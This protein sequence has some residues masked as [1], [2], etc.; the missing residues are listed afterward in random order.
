M[1]IGRFRIPVAKEGYPF[2]L[3]GVV[4]TLVFLFTGPSA[5][6]LLFFLGTA[7]TIFFFRDPERTISSEEGAILS[8]A[9]GRI[10]FAGRVFEGRYLRRDLLKVSIFMSLLDVHVNRAPVDGVVVKKSY[11][12]GR[13]ISANR[14]KASLENEQCFYLLDTGSEEIG[15]V[16]IAGLI[17]RRIVSW[18][19]EGERVRR[20]ERIGLIRFGSRVDLFLPL[21]TELSVKKG[22]RVYGGIT[23]L[24][25][26]RS[27]CH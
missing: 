8:P 7:F 9:D 21:H 13:F 6:A 18:K 2:I 23:V 22:D 3:V 5:L 11:N 17:A 12:P 26:L 10:V 24:G 27:K 15:M 14:D 4:L 16:Q 20:G 19:G 1:A 25:L